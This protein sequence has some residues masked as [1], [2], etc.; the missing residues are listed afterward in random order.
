MWRLTGVVQDLGQGVQGV[1]ALVRWAPDPDI[2]E[3]AK[4]RRMLE[5]KTTRAAGPCWAPG[6]KGVAALACPKPHGLGVA[7]AEWGCPH[8][9]AATTTAMPDGDVHDRRTDT[10]AITSTVAAMS[11]TLASAVTV[12]VSV[13]ASMYVM[14]L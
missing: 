6:L 3:P 11:P 7:R 8:T 13:V 4:V 12:V 9:A 14:Q 1:V 5:D 2:S 10:L